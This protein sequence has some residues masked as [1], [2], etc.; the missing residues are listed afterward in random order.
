M[1]GHEVA[2]TEREGRTELSV[3]GPN[4]APGY[5]TEDGLVPLPADEEGFYRTGDAASVRGRR[6]ER[7]TLAFDGRLAEDFKLSS[8][9]KVRAGALRA[10]LLAHCTP[11]V[12]E[13]V[14]GGESCE[15]LVALVFPA[16]TATTEQIARVLAAW[17]AA[18]PAGSTRIARFALAGFEPDRSRG[19]VSDKGQIVRS[20]FLRNHAAVFDALQ[21]GDGLT[22]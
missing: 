21:E 22:P 17:N 1:P 4:V 15:T 5:L 14:L 10:A 19:E 18:N 3:R 20:A 7:T 13:I 2:L 9:T 6:D 12:D 16:R 8:G 11:L